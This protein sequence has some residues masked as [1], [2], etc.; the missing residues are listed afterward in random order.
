ML[1][2]YPHVPTGYE[3]GVNVAVQSY[4]GKVFWGFTAD[5][6]A[7]P[8]VG[9]LRDFLFPSLEELG[10]SAGLKKAPPQPAARKPRARRPAAVTLPTPI[11][12]P[13]PV[14]IDKQPAPAETSPS[15]APEP[16]ENEPLTEMAQM[17]S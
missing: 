9:T 6:D 12:P 1:T 7:A 11:A 14:V 5:A 3:L 17:A 4:D 13:A 8:D 16:A 2:S 10:H 15:P